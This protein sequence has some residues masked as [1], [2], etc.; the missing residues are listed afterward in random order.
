MSCF[1]IGSLYLNSTDNIT[2]CGVGTPGLWYSRSL[3]SPMTSNI[4]NTYILAV[5]YS[6]YVV[7]SQDQH[8]AWCSHP[9]LVPQ[10]WVL[11]NSPGTNFYNI[12][13]SINV[14]ISMCRLTSTAMSWGRLWVSNLD[15]LPVARILIGR[16]WVNHVP[17][18]RHLQWPFQTLH[19]QTIQYCNVLGMLGFLTLTISPVKDPHRQVLGKSC[20][21]P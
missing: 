10:I 8:L 21:Q 18:L 6:W 20:P 15:H 12:I 13:M 14:S 19:V 7:S 3:N 1:S 9:P 11:L 2:P 4:L 5:L 16:C 17:N